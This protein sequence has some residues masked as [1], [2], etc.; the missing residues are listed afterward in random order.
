MKIFIICSKRFYDR[1]PPIQSELEA[2]G[3]IITLPNSYHDPL[4]EERMRAQGEGIHAA[5]KARM[6][7]QSAA[8]ISNMDAVLVL[9]FEKNGMQN[10]IGGATFLEMYEAWKLGKSIYM[11][12]DIPEGMLKDEICGFSPVLIHGDLS[13][14]SSIVL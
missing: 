8:V 11:Y 1:I 12:N 2:A 13:K 3:H 14:L 4:M 6:I 5:W 9:N 10:Y 7:H